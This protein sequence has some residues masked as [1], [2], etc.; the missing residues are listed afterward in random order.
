M[1]TI[2]KISGLLAVTLLLGAGSAFGQSDNIA[3]N[4]EVLAPLTI[5]GDVD[6]EFGNVTPGVSKTIGVA[7]DVLA[8]GTGRTSET[9]GLF[10]IGK[11]AG[12]VTLTWTLPTELDGPDEAALPITFADLS[13]GTQLGL[14]NIGDTG[15]PVP[16]TPGVQL[17]TLTDT[18][19][20]DAYTAATAFTVKIGGTVVPG[21]TQAAGS[22]TG[23]ITLT[24]AYN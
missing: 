11:G 8:G 3:A 23:T 9:T 13:D 15:S 20:A 22:Y 16:F 4:A 5:E 24:A 1:N 7:N 19:T 14:L 17:N 10:T 18:G 6:L 12:S 21:A 2:K